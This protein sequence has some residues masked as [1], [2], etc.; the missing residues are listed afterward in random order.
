VVISND[1]LICYS[2]FL[3][4]FVEGAKKR[5]Q[6]SD[7]GVVPGGASRGFVFGVCVFFGE[8]GGFARNRSLIGQKRASRSTYP[9]ES[10]SG[11]WAEH[12]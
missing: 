12:K 7:F 8:P 11:A 1:G 6:A 5:R 3:S 10:G 9:A 2:V 4:F